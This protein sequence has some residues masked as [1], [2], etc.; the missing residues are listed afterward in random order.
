MIESRHVV[1]RREGKWRHTWE[2]WRHSRVV[3]PGWKTQ[4]EARLEAARLDTAEAVALARRDGLPGA[5]DEL[6]R[7]RREP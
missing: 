2:I 1:L 6:T 4:R 7:M 3:S 5:L